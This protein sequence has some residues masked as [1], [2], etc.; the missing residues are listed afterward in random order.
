MKK[1][2]L[3]LM[4]LTIVGAIIANSRLLSATSFFT[5]ET[6]A[7]EPTNVATSPALAAEDET[8]DSIAA[9]IVTRS[10]VDLTFTNDETYPWTINGNEIKNGNWAHLQKPVFSQI[11]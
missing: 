7:N 11:S 4:A 3:T 8:V 9:A 6:E 1:C 2:I 5:N 10:D